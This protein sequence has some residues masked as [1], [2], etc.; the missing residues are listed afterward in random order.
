MSSGLLLLMPQAQ[1]NCIIDSEH[2]HSLGLVL[3]S[4]YPLPGW[5]L[6]GGLK[7]NAILVMV[8]HYHVQE[9]LSSVASHMNS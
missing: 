7:M 3:I 8:L 9:D 2:S 1:A 4:S 6:T 5:S